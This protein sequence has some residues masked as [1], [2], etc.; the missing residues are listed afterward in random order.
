MEA[1]LVH[2][3][4]AA[5]TA[6]AAE[7]ELQ[8]DY[9]VVVHDSNKLGLRLLPCDV[10]AR[11]AIGGRAVAALEVELAR[12]LAATAT[13]VATLEPRVEP[14]VYERGGFT[15]TFWTYY[16]EEPFS[17]PGLGPLTSTGSGNHSRKTCL[18]IWKGSKCSN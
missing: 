9:V 18:E 10:F 12:R 6:L 1:E 16:P 5:T 3:A 2:R 15:V 13:P 14:R 17:V 8:V 11:V 7:L 4:T